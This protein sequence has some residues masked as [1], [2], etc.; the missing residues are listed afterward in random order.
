MQDT[1]EEKVMAKLKEA[2]KKINLG[3]PL[4]TENPC[5]GPI[6]SE[7]QYKKVM[8]YIQTGI[9]GMCQLDEKLP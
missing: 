8:G 4:T 1:I 5:M 9:K 3:D 7:N 6:V 2:V